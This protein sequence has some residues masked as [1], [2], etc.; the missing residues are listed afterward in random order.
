VGF[1][2]CFFFFG[3]LGGFLGFTLVREHLKKLLTSRRKILLLGS[4]RESI[5]PSKT[6]SEKSKLNKPLP[7]AAEYNHSSLMT[8]E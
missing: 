1:I 2:G 7:L 4:V 8:I 5:M 3:L 6:S